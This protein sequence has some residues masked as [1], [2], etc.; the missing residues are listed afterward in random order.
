MYGN[1]PDT[2]KTQITSLLTDTR[3]LKSELATAKDQ[4]Y[5]DIKSEI[6]GRS[7]KLISL[8]EPYS[9][10]SPGSLEATI[11]INSL[12]EDYPQRLA[13]ESLTR[14]PVVMKLYLTH[15]QSKLTDT[16]FLGFPFHYFYTAVFLLILFVTLCIIYNVLI[17][18][19]LKKEGIVE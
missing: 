14:L 9:G 11:L 10:F 8:F 16:K 4:E 5:L 12:K 6:S 2:I 13:D 19:R 17:E 15:N 1:I 3:K 7:Q 18:W